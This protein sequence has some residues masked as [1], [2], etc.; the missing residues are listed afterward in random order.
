MT[1]PRNCRRSTGASWVLLEFRT[2][3]IQFLTQAELVTPF[4]IQSCE[5]RK[6]EGVEKKKKDSETS[7]DELI[8]EERVHESEATTSPPLNVSIILLVSVMMRPTSG[9]VWSLER[10]LK[11]ER[12]GV[13]VKRSAPRF[14]I[15]F[16]YPDHFNPKTG[17]PTHAVV[18]RHR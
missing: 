13:G 15:C 17:T 1:G 11:G 16:M 14:C 5:Y 9:D 7:R 8:R 10:Q 18:R 4:R 12:K 3:E 6:R 2:T